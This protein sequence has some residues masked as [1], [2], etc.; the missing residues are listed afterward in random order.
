M[1]AMLL[2]RSVK[3]LTQPLSVSSVVFLVC[4]S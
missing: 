3:D 4:L 2:P 1:G